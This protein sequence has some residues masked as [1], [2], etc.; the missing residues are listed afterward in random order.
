MEKEYTET[1]GPGTICCYTKKLLKNYAVMRYMYATRRGR[2]CDAW[3]TEEKEANG[4][5]E[6]LRKKAGTLSGEAAG[7][8]DVREKLKW[9]ELTIQYVNA[10]LDCLRTYPK[11]GELYYSI[12][13]MH[14]IQDM[15]RKE[16]AYAL[17][18]SVPT[19]QRRMQEALKE[20][21][22]LLWDGM[23]RAIRDRML[24]AADD[25]IY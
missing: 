19:Y 9:L 21:D 6:E 23:D 1:A 22:I 3:Q 7:E 2:V 20:L 24:A 14:Y 17:N 13:K 8:T 18:I 15:A 5:V 4:T 12:I 16:V 10:N 11:K 25:R